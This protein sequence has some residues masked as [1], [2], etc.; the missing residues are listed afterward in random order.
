MKRAIYFF[1]LITIAISCSKRQ[2]TKQ[3]ISTT[4]APLTYITKYL[5][6]ST[7]QINTLIPKGMSPES[8]DFSIETLKKLHDS[9]ACIYFGTLPFEQAQLLPVLKSD[10]S[11]AQIALSDG[12]NH[13]HNNLCN[14]E[15]HVCDP[16]VWLSVKQMLQMSLKIA[17]EIKEQYP[18][19]ADIVDRN[20]EKLQTQ[21]TRL[22]SSFTTILASKNIRS[23]VIYH[24][25]LSAFAEDYG[26]QQISIEEHGKE[27]SP[28]HIKQIIEQVKQQ[29]I[30]LLL[31]QAQND[32]TQ[33]KQIA[34]ECNM[35]IVGFN[36]LADN[37]IAEMQKLAETLN[38]HLK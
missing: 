26:L 32:A 15:H 11:I 5:T 31:V 16:H 25:A 33:C 30:S 18:N 28:N 21:L 27:P 6:D 19:I 7:I 14:H 37:Y 29:G 13:T 22:D 34:D 9:K 35:T 1:L 8:G 3:Y 10:T 36:P 12:H 20:S 4:I 23:F 24:P 38:N 17:E 2:N